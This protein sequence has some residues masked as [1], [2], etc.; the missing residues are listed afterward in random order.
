MPQSQT[1]WSGHPEQEEGPDSEVGALGR[2]Q[3]F[4][5]G[6]GAVPWTG[7]SENHDPNQAG[8]EPWSNQ[9]GAQRQDGESVD[10]QAD[11]D[12]Q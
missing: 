5:F 11:W 10:P 6:H 9:G 8:R 2:S 3:R 4:W 7:A 12:L 1:V